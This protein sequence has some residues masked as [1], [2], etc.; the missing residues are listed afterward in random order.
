[1]DLNIKLKMLKKLYSEDTCN[2]IITANVRLKSADLL[3]WII[4]EKNEKLILP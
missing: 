1:M 4:N 3:R 2:E